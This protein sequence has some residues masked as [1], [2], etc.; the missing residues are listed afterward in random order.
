MRRDL[1]AAVAGASLGVVA[2]ALVD[3][4]RPIEWSLIAE[5]AL[6]LAS[7]DKDCA[8]FETRAEAQKYFEEHRRID[9][10]KL[11]ADGD[12]RACEYLR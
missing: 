2:A 3:D 6:Q 5:I 10:H 1:L 12:G 11:D 7:P 9:L 4:R 8:D